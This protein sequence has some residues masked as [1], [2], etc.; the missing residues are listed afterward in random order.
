MDIE[1]G[2]YL[3]IQIVK[4]YLERQIKIIEDE[5]ADANKQIKAAKEIGDLSENATYEI[6]KNKKILLEGLLS[7]NTKYL[8]KAKVVTVESIENSEYRNLYKVFTLTIADVS[9]EQPLTI[10][11]D[12]VLM[13]NIEVDFQC[14]CISISTEIGRKL[15]SYVKN[16]GL[17]RRYSM[18]LDVG[19][20]TL[21]IDVISIR[22]LTKED[23]Y[24]N[25]NN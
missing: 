11:K 7:V 25:T 23:I 1:K 3:L 24:G 20:V 6:N 21:K 22:D 9:R 5:L 4:D 16:T 14:D 12:F 8:E 2:N 17:R 10:Q 13:P 15:L 18:W 19:E